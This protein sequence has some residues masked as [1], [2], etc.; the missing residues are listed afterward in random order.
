MR[1]LTSLQSVN[2][3]GV[4]AVQQPLVVQESNEVVGVIGF[5]I[6]RVKLFSQGEKWLWVMVEI[7][8]LKYGFRIGDIILLEVII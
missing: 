2:V 4:D 6:A 5:V 7:V 1:M 8:D 3:L